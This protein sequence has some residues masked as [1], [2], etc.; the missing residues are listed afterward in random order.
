MERSTRLAIAVGLGITAGGLIFI[1]I[2]DGIMYLGNLFNDNSGVDFGSSLAMTGYA[3]IIILIIV[4][5][6]VVG[7]LIY[8]HSQSN[9]SGWN[10]F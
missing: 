7:Y 8:R 9:S 4:F 1:L 3:M 2:G 6:S 10:G 5:V